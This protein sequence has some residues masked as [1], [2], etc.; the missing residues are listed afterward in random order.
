MPKQT[1][2]PGI[3]FKRPKLGCSDR[4]GACAKCEAD[5]RARMPYY[6]AVF[7]SPETGKETT[8]KVD[9]PELDRILAA[10]LPATAPERA[11]REV[12]I[13]KTLAE[14]G[15][16]KRLE[17]DALKAKPATAKPIA[18]S[19]EAARDR[20]FEDKK[21]IRPATRA[22]Y[23]SAINAFDRWCNET[24]TTLVT[25][26]VDRLRKFRS[27]AFDQP[28]RRQMKG[29]KRGIQEAREGSARSLWTINSD[30]NSA[31][32]FL[33]FC[34]RVKYLPLLTMDEIEFG[35]QRY[36]TE[37]VEIDY[38]KPAAL[39][40]LLIAC[41]KHDADCFKMTRDEQARGQKNGTPRYTPIT[42]AVIG[43][44]LSGMRIA[45]L[46]LVTFKNHLDL[47]AV[48]FEDNEVGHFK[49]KASETK[50]RRA[51]YVTFEVSPLLKRL[52]AVLQQ[53]RNGKGTVFGLSTREEAETA[54]RRLRDEY[55]APPNFTWQL[56]R[57]TC[58][59]YLNC[60]PGIYGARAGLFTPA[61]IGGSPFAAA[62]AD[63][64]SDR[65]GHTKQV[66]RD[67]YIK[68][69]KGMP[70][71]ATTLEAAMGI[72]DAIAEYIE[73]LERSIAPRDNVVQLR[74]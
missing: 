50:T 70:K 26:D 44:I 36:D 33:R 68:I 23:T 40:Q 6:R 15:R 18:M 59:T 20:F 52:V 74:R 62:A 8:I 45:E 39:R 73:S 72:E 58:D 43:A 29:H 14:W 67:F 16:R 47:F 12:R 64:S 34:L 51:R 60:A 31:S 42:P 4:C 49:L 53:M 19:I 57:K 24:K 28:M 30:L 65:Q 46:C 66:A 55:G 2:H 69:V 32:I 41:G 35:L 21:Q 7:A 56:L 11:K 63:R 10:P 71:D 13:E 27:W 54:M 5:K 61:Q 17:L 38:M 3:K 37:P 25:L 48:D 1:P 22:D 9:S